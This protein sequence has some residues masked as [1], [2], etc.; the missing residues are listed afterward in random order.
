MKKG[1]ASIAAWIA[2]V[3]AVAILIG[4]PWVGQFLVINQAPAASDAIIVLGGE[5]PERV[6]TAVA[7]YRA[8]YAPRL[9]MSGGNPGGGAT[10]ASV[11]AHAA[12]QMGVPSRV[13]RLDTHSFSTLQNAQDTRAI[14]VAGHWSSAIVVS[15]DY[16]MR[17]VRLLFHA[18]YRGTH[19]KLTYVAAPSRVFNAQRWWANSAS[20]RLT[21]SEYAEMAVNEVQVSLLRVRALVRGPRG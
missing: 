17:R 10:Q 8:G 19:I 11:M 20:I 13:I 2:G 4:G 18:I 5:M 15:S 21:L 16:H 14:M 3:C 9:I 7:L 12:E 6:E 1:Y